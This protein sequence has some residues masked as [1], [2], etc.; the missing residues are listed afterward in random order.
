MIREPEERTLHIITKVD[1][2]LEMWQGSQKQHT[3]QMESRAQTKQ[4]R[5]IG[6]IA[7]TEEMIKASWLSFEHNEE[8]A[9]KLTERSPLP[10]A[11]S[12]NN[13]TRGQTQVIN[14]HQI[15]T[16]D[17]HPPKR[18]VDSAPETILN[19]ENWLDWNWNFDDSNQIN[20]NREADNESDIERGNGIDDLESP[21]QGDVSAVPKVP[22]FIWPTCRSQKTAQMVLR[23]VNT[24]ASRKNKWYKKNFDGMCQSIFTT[25][26][27]LFDQELQLGK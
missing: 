14:V 9:S 5:A 21:N 25:F 22:R 17:R 23:T 15:K 3:I 19:T 20:D 11:L 12:A 24:M 18:D 6:Y 1:N 10:P 7:D 16:I 2:S 13:L 27:V 8:A 26:F 4:N